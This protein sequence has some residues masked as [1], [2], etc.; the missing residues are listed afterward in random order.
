MFN[1]MKSNDGKKVVLLSLLKRAGG[2]C[3][4]VQI[5]DMNYILELSW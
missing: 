3:E 4:P 2:C 5:E 1:K